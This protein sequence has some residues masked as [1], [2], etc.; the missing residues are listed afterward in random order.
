MPT[1]NLK[2]LKNKKYKL[3]EFKGEWKDS[4]GHP[5]HGS[6]WIVYGQSG[7]GKTDFSVQLAN[8]MSQFGKVLY[9]SKEQSD[10]NSIWKCF[11]R[12]EMWDNK[13][14]SLVYDEDFK[15]LID[16]L[17]KRNY[18][19]TIILDSIDY[20]K[21]TE[22]QYKILDTYKNK[23]FI[24]ISW[25]EGKKPKSTAGK[26]IEFMVDIK[27]AVDGY[28]AKPRGRYEG[29]LPFVIWEDGAKRSKK[30]AFLNL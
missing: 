2:S 29:N 27:I 3:Y 24:F 20:L 1:I 11:D 23:T 28:V 14:V 22:E 19:K 26:A 9:F 25:Q 12:H 4:F 8:Y 13:S 16:K 6:R 5:E 15:Y 21:L 10:K 18:Y 7:E 30:H 17:N